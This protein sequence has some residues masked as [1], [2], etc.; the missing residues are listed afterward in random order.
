VRWGD[1]GNPTIL[2]GGTASI[3]GEDSLF[4]ASLQLQLAET[5]TNLASVV[6]AAHETDGAARMAREQWLRKYR[7]VRV[8]F[9]RPADGEGL[10]AAARQAF[11][12]QCRVEMCRADLCRAE[13]LV[14]IEGVAT[15]ED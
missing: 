8:Y 11:G 3:R 5:L 6:E 1:D 13:L 7:D 10:E 2:V 4:P 12:P 14:E 9:P 15:L